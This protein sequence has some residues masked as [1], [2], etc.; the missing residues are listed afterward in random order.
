MLYVLPTP[1]GNLEDITIRAKGFLSSLSIFFCEDTR[2][3]KRLFHL[4]NIPHEGKQFFSLTSFTS[5]HQLDTF[6]NLLRTQ[7]AWLLSDAGT[8]GLSDPGKTIIRLCRENNIP[9][10]VLPWTNALVPA[11]VAARFP[12]NRFAFYGFLPKKK[13]KQT[14]QREIIAS[15]IPVFLYESV[16]RIQKLLEEMIALWFTGRVLIARELSKLHEQLACGDVTIILEQVKKWTI[17]SKGEFVV[18]FYNGSIHDATGDDDLRGE[19]D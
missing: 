10:S 8:P 7:D 6:I 1:V 11:V 16:H 2:T 19:T 13:G 15:P 18:G 17:P 14:M 9:F 5:P 3:A 4:Y 12:T